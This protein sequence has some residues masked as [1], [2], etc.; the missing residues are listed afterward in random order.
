[1]PHHYNK[2]GKKA[3]MYPGPTSKMSLKKKPK[4][5]AKRMAR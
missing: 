2:K 4:K 5:P 3:K 1:M